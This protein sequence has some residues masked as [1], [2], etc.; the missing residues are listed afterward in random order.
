MQR[1]T[2]T[3]DDELMVAV[4]AFMAVRGYTNRS[5]ALRDLARAGLDGTA[6]AGADSSS[7][8]VGALAYVYDHEARELPR[9]LTQAFHGHHDLVLATLH[10]HLDHE[11]CME[12]AALRG[13]T[14]EVREFA[15]QVMAERG[16][17]HGRL[18]LVPARLVQE[19]HAHGD[20]SPHAHAHLHPRG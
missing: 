6:E 7:A 17:R 19:R 8:C 15:G 10:V 16:V 4:D 13:R 1:V 20:E 14:G 5:E 18:M 11:F 2:I 12:V 3:L 9:R